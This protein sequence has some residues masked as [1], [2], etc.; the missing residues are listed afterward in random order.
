MALD[1]V[2]QTEIGLNDREEESAGK[3][4]TAR[5]PRADFAL[6]SPQNPW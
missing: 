4:Q 6:P 3:D 2:S 1:G 5:I